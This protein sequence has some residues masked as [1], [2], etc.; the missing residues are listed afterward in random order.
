MW[1]CPVPLKNRWGRIE[2]GPDLALLCLT[3]G[4]EVSL[5]RGEQD[6]PRGWVSPARN[7]LEPAWQVNVTGSA[8]APIRRGFLLLPWPH[9]L[10]DDLAADLD[11]SADPPTLNLR[12]AGQAH[13]VL[14]C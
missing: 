9:E 1:Y 5:H 2:G 6:P 4:V 7:T 3:D 14:I 11:L 12:V 10:P 13:L 8:P